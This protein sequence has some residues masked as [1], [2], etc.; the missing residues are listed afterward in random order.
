MLI[1]DHL[2][3]KGSLT[4]NT[5]VLPILQLQSLTHVERSHSKSYFIGDIVRIGISNRGDIQAGDY[6]AV[7]D[8]NSEHRPLHL[9]TTDNREITWEIPTHRENRFSHVEVFKRENREL[10]LGDCIHWSRTEK[11]QGLFSAECARV[12]EIFPY[13]VTVELANHTMFIFDPREPTYQHWEH[14]YASTVYAAQ[15]TTKSIVLAHLESYRTNLTTQPAFLVAL[16]RVVDTFRI[17][18]DNRYALLNLI[19]KNTGLKKSSLEIINIY[20]SN[21]KS[22]SRIQITANDKID[23]QNQ[24]VVNKSERDII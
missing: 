14:G 18:T 13:Q 11:S 12:T 6:A 24:K 3:Q 23:C 4:G 19:Q 1:R 2:K 9:K 16:T 15:G 5:Q 21:S 10:Q 8:I 7:I 17:Y 20:P 22:D